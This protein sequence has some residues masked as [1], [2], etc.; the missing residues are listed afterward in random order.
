MFVISDVHN[1]KKHPFNVVKIHWAKTDT[2]ETTEVYVE[3]KV[4]KYDVFE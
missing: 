3:V 4:S 2:S 1:K